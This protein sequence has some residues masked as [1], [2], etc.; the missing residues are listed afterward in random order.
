MVFGPHS[1]A[2][3]KLPSSGV[4]VSERLSSL[5][6]IIERNSLSVDVGTISVFSVST[7]IKI[8]SYNLGPRT[9]LSEQLGSVSMIAAIAKMG[10]L[11]G[12]VLLDLFMGLDFKRLLTKN[13][14]VV[15]LMRWQSCG[16]DSVGGA[17][18]LG[19]R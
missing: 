12:F 15:V 17:C 6:L 11:N 4:I 5:D 18:A 3:F 7:L 9:L 10:S 13:V 1:D 8:F 16:V 14:L 19:W 2:G